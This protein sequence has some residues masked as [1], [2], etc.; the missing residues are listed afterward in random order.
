MPGLVPQGDVAAAVPAELGATA[1]GQTV[2]V[3]LLERQLQLAELTALQTLH[4]L[5]SLG[6]TEL[7]NRCPGPY[8]HIP[9]FISSEMKIKL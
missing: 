5:V 1:A 4:T 8:T 7:I 2:L 6:H 9:I 3:Q